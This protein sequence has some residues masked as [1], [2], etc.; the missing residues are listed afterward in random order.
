MTEALLKIPK[1]FRRDEGDMGIDWHE[2]PIS[3]ANGTF[4]PMYD[5]P[6]RV[7]NC[8]MWHFIDDVTLS[9]RQIQIFEL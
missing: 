3:L 6:R 4:E 9:I 5:V 1:S 7:L 2:F 8:L